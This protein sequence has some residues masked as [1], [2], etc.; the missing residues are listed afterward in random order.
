MLRLENASL[1]VDLL[2]PSDPVDRARQG[3]R[4]AHGGYIWQV[5]DRRRGPL[6]AGPEFP[7]P[8]PSPF[9]GQ[10]LPE[11]FRHRTRDGQPLTWSGAAGLGVGVGLLA[12]VPPDTVA[13]A[14]PCAWTVTATADRAIFQTRHAGAGRACALTREVALQERE[15]HSASTLTN[16]GTEPLALQW[17]AHPFWPL[18][19]GRARVS[20][21]RG[22]RLPENP[23]FDLQADGTL[24]FRRP[25]V[26]PDDSQ[27][28]LLALPPGQPLTLSVDH[29]RLA[30]VTLA[31][32][33]VPDECPVWANAHTLSVEPY[34]TLRLAPGE[35]R[36]WHLIHGF[37]A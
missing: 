12:S 17:F 14:T 20:L 1:R 6:L 31:T 27:F 30:R 9:N 33:F 3:T 36:R 2:E 23:G 26:T 35:T 5:H 16:L 21:P 32:S 13:L 19:Q 34:L 15:L 10:G 18:R 4:Y 8:S 24:S 29:P 7:A 22:T 37:E 11:S 25:F 28:A